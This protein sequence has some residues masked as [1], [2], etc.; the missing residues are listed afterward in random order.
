MIAVLKSEWRKAT[1]TSLW[2][3]LAICLAAYMALLA[4]MFGFLFG[5]PLEDGGMGNEMMDPVE[6]AKTVYGITPSL[7]YVFA[8]VL[9]AL[10]VTNEYRH[11]TVTSTFLAEPRRGRVLVGKLI[12]QAGMGAILGVVG[13]VASIAVGAIS[14]TLA[15]GET[16]LG[17]PSVWATIIWSVVAL[18]LWGMVGVGIGTLI[19]N[20]IASVIV[21]LAFTQFVEPILRAVL[22]AIDLT[23]SLAKFMPGA[24]GEALA[25]AS[26]YAAGGLGDILSRTEG[27]LVLLA[28]ALVFSGIGWLTTLRRDVS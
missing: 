16:A 25:G 17:E 4:A 27:G 15:G 21:I 23:S 14:L 8:L 12:T 28:Y 3:I 24:A 9:G 11:R 2:W 18:G 26:F 22:A 7:G 13:G 10:A 5:I 20:Q 1:A 19:P 6:A